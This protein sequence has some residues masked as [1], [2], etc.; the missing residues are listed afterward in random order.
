M[1]KIDGLIETIESIFPGTK[2]E[3]QLAL[4]PEDYN[5]LHDAIED[6]FR[7]GISGGTSHSSLGRRSGY[8]TLRRGGQT[9][10]FRK[11]PR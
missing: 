5:K 4:L 7:D 11:G 2:F 3:I 10:H 8:D 6:H 9:I 1:E